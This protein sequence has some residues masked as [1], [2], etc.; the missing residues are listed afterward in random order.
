MERPE[1]P[2]PRFE[3]GAHARVTHATVGWLDGMRPLCINPD[4]IVVVDQAMHIPTVGWY[5]QVEYAGAHAWVIE[6]YLALTTVPVLPSATAAIVPSE[7][8]EGAQS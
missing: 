2:D 5:Y 4:D 7:T 8:P 1:R 3:L 6:R